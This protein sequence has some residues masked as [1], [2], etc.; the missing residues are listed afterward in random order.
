MDTDT[1]ETPRLA[2]D[3]RV[4]R[5]PRSIPDW[6][7]AKHPEGILTVNGFGLLLVVFERGIER[8]VRRVSSLENFLVED[9]DLLI[10]D[11]RIPEK[12]R[13]Y[14]LDKWLPFI[15]VGGALFFT[16]LNI[17]RFNDTLRDFFLK[18]PNHWQYHHEL[19]TGLGIAERV[20]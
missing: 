9:T 10:A 3:P 1:L 18:W 4:W 20:L 11:S 12:Q 2:R 16:K 13:Q 8:K 6:I 19:G 17:T 15:S 14:I 5:G 7:A